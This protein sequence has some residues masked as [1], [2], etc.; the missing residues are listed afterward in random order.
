MSCSRYDYDTHRDRPEKDQRASRCRKQRQERGGRARMELHDRL[1]G[2]DWKGVER[3][4]RQEKEHAV[5]Q[6]I[7]GTQAN[8]RA[9]G[10][11]ASTIYDGLD[12]RERLFNAFLAQDR[13]TWT[14][15]KAL[16][17]GDSTKTRL[18]LDIVYKKA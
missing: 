14:D 2:C 7:P 18:V 8:E 12:E 15:F 13:K 4:L 5:C 16:V 6:G 11:S 3:L 17:R 10:M 9:N 1:H